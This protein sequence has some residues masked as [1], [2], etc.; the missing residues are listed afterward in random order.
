MRLPAMV[1]LSDSVSREQREALKI[2]PTLPILGF[3]I[4]KIGELSGT[5]T[6]SLISEV[7]S[8]L[9]ETGLDI[10]D[11]KR[12]GSSAAYQPLC[13]ELGAKLND[14]YRRFAQV[15]PSPDLA[16]EPIHLGIVITPKPGTPEKWNYDPQWIY[17][18]V[19]AL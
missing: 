5:A 15:E 12:L 7:R 8:I 3:S 6:K 9:G 4:P 1:D 14:E 19:G 13:D 2:D 11:L 10:L 17:K 16:K 18:R